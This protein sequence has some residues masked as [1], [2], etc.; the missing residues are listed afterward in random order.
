MN[1]KYAVINQ[2]DTQSVTQFF[3]QD[4]INLA[5]ALWQSIVDTYKG[6]YKNDIRLV[7]VYDITPSKT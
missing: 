2:R 4:E 3:E 1:L 6:E 7:A 5:I